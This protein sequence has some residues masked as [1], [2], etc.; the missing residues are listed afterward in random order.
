MVGPRRAAALALAAGALLARPAA[1]EV[2]GAVDPVGGAEALT[3][4]APA[5]GPS[6]DE[7]SAA[8]RDP[9]AA[10]RVEALQAAGEGGDGRAVPLLAG[11]LRAD[12][13]PEVRGWALR[14]LER[15][16][17]PE[18]RDALAEA[19]RSDPDPRARSLACR[20]AEGGGEDAPFRGAPACAREEP[21]GPPPSED[22][23]AALLD[24]RQARVSRLIEMEM[25]RMAE[26]RLRTPPGS[27]SSTGMLAFTGI[28]DGI[29]IP[30]MLTGTAV[31]PF[32]FA[33]PFVAP[34]G[35]ADTAFLSGVQHAVAAR[36]ATVDPAPQAVAWGLTLLTF[37]GAWIGSHI[38]LSNGMWDEDSPERNTSITLITL[39]AAAE[40]ANLFVRGIWW[41]GAIRRGYR[42]MVEEAA[43]GVDRAEGA[44]P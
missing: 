39:S 44:E 41:R 20:L 7:L 1:G 43:E 21:S 28:V 13:S 19:A 34:A 35:L 40:L 10:R 6:L 17:T 33:G 11:A 42:A 32:S 3:A 30:L 25:E 38:L 36:G 31:A 2:A 16:G 23:A 24:R 9:V 27:G 18:A 8:L 5:A 14:A 29:G 26:E 22:P 12:P 4:E 15:I 37:A